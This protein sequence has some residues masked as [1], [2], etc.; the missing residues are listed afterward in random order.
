V[1]ADC[2]PTVTI[3]PTVDAFASAMATK[4]AR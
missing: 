4:K 2:G 3:P 1:A